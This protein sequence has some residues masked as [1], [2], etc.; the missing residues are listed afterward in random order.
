M[1]KDFWKK[2]QSILTG[3]KSVDVVI[4][5]L[6]SVRDELHECAEH[7]TDVAAFHA[8]VADAATESQQLALDEAAKATKVADNIGQ[9]VG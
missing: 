6:H 8:E 4:G 9:L 7:H 5:K 3:D 1:F 2:I